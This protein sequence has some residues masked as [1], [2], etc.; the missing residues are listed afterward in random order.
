[1]NQFDKTFFGMDAADALVTRLR[2]ERPALVV[3]SSS[4]LSKVSEGGK[5]LSRVLRSPD[6]LI[7]FFE[8][9]SVESLL[10]A[11]SRLLKDLD[12]AAIGGDYGAQPRSRILMI[13]TAED[14]AT[15][16][17]DALLR[18][19]SGLKGVPLYVVLLAHTPD[20]LAGEPSLRR[21][22][23]KALFWHLD[24]QAP[25]APAT[26]STPVP[27]N[28]LKMDLAPLVD[29]SDEEFV[30][31]SPP[32]NLKTFYLGIALVLVLGCLIGG[33]W[34][35]LRNP[36]TNVNQWF[37]KVTAPAPQ[38]PKPVLTD[39]RDN[40]EKSALAHA[41]G[42]GNFVLSCGQYRNPEIL[43]AVEAKVKALAPT[44]RLEHDGVTELFAGGFL[45]QDAAQKALA[46]LLPIG[47]C[48]TEIRTLDEKTMN[49]AAG[50]AANAKT[51]QGG[52]SH[53]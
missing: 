45:T 25:E 33:G 8:P 17:V 42:Q 36:D 20:G 22:Q 48:Q 4:L 52:N 34:Y 41:S 5:T 53:E 23:N 10:E 30:E 35:A 44:R 32:K 43:D 40:K 24:G 7:E 26:E 1:M 31:E 47:P 18:V 6:S 21:L 11:T 3:V 13:D 29:E 51:D 50:E 38:T 12:I 46:V 27:E 37:N 9:S 2:Q 39:D 28:T 16:E 19:L 49:G 14:L 15:E